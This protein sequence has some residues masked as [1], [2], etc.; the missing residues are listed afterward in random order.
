M[1]G[2][3]SNLTWPVKIITY[4][5]PILLI[6]SKLTLTIHTL[7]PKDMINKIL[8]INTYLLMHNI[9]ILYLVDI[10]VFTNK[11]T[12]V[13]NR[14]NSAWGVVGRV[15]LVFSDSKPLYRTDSPKE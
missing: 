8:H 12:I 14:M 5:L 7:A 13:H 11:L 4:C 1:K 9:Y 10:S 3:I 2:F 6:T 15:L